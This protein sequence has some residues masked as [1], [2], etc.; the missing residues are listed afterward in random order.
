MASLKMSKETK[1]I[2]VAISTGMEVKNL[3]LGDFYKLFK[4]RED[5]RLVAFVPPEKLEK[6]KKEFEH[7]RCI[8]EPMIDLKSSAHPTKKFFNIVKLASIPTRTIRSRQEF[9]YLNGGSFWGFWGRGIVWLLGHTRVFRGLL[10]AVEYNVFRDDKVWYPYFDRYRPDAVFGAA[11]K[12]EEPMVLL[13]AAKRRGIASVGMA[14]SWDNFSSKVFLSV[15]PDILLVQ[16]QSMVGEVKKWCDYPTEKV[17]VVGFPQFDRYR[18]PSWI[19]TKAEVA[20]NIGADPSKRWIT[21]FT[22]GLLMGGLRMEDLRDQSDVLTEAIEKGELANAELLIRIHPVDPV[23]FEIKSPKVKLVNFGRGFDFS[24]DD[25]KLLLNLVRLSDVTINFGS[26]MSLEAGILDRPVISIG[27]N[28]NNDDQIPNYRKL[29]WALANT[30]HYAPINNSGGVWLAKSPEDLVSA[31]KAYLENP[32][33]HSEGRKV[34]VKEL[35]G[36]VD[37]MSG[38]RIFDAVISLTEK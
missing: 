2:F 37:G 32:S 31:V 10:R 33:L 27:F 6:Y 9:V 8:V 4:E 7:E 23:K 3:L 36:E 14:A 34:F 35:V 15:H 5:L 26:T 18:D 24:T 38:Q 20:K 28:G 19:M 25:V 13:K 16:N 29:S 17:K 1:T 21:Y 11:L 30:T 12:Y 22:G